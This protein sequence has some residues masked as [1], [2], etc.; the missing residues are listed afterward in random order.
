VRR[1]TLFAAAFGAA[2]AFFLDP[3][4]GRSRRSRAADQLRSRWRKRRVKAERQSRYDA[5]RVVGEML[6]TRGAGRF[7]PVDDVSVQQH[8]T[9]VL[10]RLPVPTSKISVEVVEGVVRVRGQLDEAGHGEVV[11]AALSAE[12]GVRDVESLLHLAGEAPP[13]KAAALQASAR[14]A[15]GQAPGVP[16]PS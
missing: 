15:A 4:L 6:R 11:L 2:S 3:R 5:K 13:N 8:L 9:A 14:A 10:A 1:R 12:P 7:R 16:P